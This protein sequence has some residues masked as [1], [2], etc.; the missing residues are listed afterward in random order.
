MPQRQPYR[1]CTPAALTAL[2]TLTA[3]TLAAAPGLAQ[4]VPGGPD[5]PPQADEPIPAT[6]DEPATS[7]QPGLTRGIDWL[8][9]PAAPGEAEREV[10]PEPWF[11]PLRSGGVVVGPGGHRVFVPD[12]SEREPGEGPML[13][14]PSAGLER[15]VRVLQQ[16]GAAQ[17]VRVS[18]Q[19]FLYR[20]RNYLLPAAVRFDAPAPTESRTNTDR[21]V[22]DQDAQAAAPSGPA[23]RPASGRADPDVED[24]LRELDENGGRDLAPPR[25]EPPRGRADDDRPGGDA[26]AN[27]GAGDEVGDGGDAG[28]PRD[29]APITRRRGHV[30]RLSSGAWA[31][32]PNNDTDS[33]GLQE[34]MVL[35]PC[36]ELQRL[37]RRA[38]DSAD[39]LEILLWGRVHRYGQ[40][41][42]LLPTLVQLPP[43][44]DINARQ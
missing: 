23:D 10:L 14:L 41:V 5:R 13:L 35:L 4:P 20:G 8:P 31:F 30:V 22:P 40:R 32:R 11:L 21:P 1:A 26:R 39:R 24:L 6:R 37:E 2:A 38:L 36:S 18:G 7:P 28:L 44:G 42:Y 27:A 25:R 12:M 33:A 34:P 17:R 3:C 9:E 29:G 43:A 15:I 19:V 16:P